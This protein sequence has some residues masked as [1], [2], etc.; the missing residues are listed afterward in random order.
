MVT[1]VFAGTMAIAGTAS[2]ANTSGISNVEVVE[3]GNKQAG[4]LTTL[5]VSFV[6]D[7]DGSS[8]TVIVNFPSAQFD[9]GFV[10][11]ITT[12]DVKFL[13]FTT[14]DFSSNSLAAG[15]NATIDSV[16]VSGDRKKL[17]VTL[18][19]TEKFLDTNAYQV[20]VLND[21]FENP[22]GT[23]NFGV[24]VGPEGELSSSGQTTA[25]AL[26]MVVHDEGGFDIEQAVSF[27]DGTPRVQAVLDRSVN[28]DNFEVAV[29]N[30]DGNNVTD[31]VAEST[32]DNTVHTINLQGS[33]DLTGEAKLNFTD[34]SGGETFEF[35]ITTGTTTLEDGTAPGNV[36]ALEG[37]SVAIFDGDFTSGNPTANAAFDITFEGE[38][39]ENKSLGKDADVG[40]FETEGRAAGQYNLSLDADGSPNSAAPDTITVRAF[41]FGVSADETDV[42]LLESSGTATINATIDS[43]VANRDAE[44]RLFDS[45]GDEIDNKTVTVDSDGVT[46]FDFV[47]TEEDDYDI[48]V[49]DLDTGVTDETATISVGEVTGEAS[50]SESVYNDQKGDVI[51]FTVNLA[52]SDT[53]DVGIGTEAGQSGIGYGA[54]FTVDDSDDGD[55]QVT[56]QF[57]TR[58]PSA[59]P[60][61][62]SDDD[63][64]TGFGSSGTPEALDVEAYDVNT[65]VGSGEDDVATLNLNDVS[66]DGFALYAA[67]ESSTIQDAENASEI[68]AFK[69]AGNFSEASSIAFGDYL[70]HELQVSGLEGMFANASS[71]SDAD[72][73]DDLLTT[74]S[75]TDGRLF[76]LNITIEESD[77]STAANSDKKIL[78][79]SR[80]KALDGEADTDLDALENDFGDFHVIADGDADT[81]YIGFPMTFGDNTEGNG[82]G[83]DDGDEFDVTVNITDTNSNLVDENVSVTQTFTVENRS[84][85]LDTERDESGDDL[86]SLEADS[87]QVVTGTT[88]LAPGSE[89]DIRLRATGENPFLLSQTVETDAQRNYEA[90]FDLSDRAVG[91]EFEVTATGPAQTAETVD[92]VVVESTATETPEPTATPTEEPTATPTEE[93]T[94]TPTEEPT[95]TETPG[96]PGFGVIVALLAFMAAALLAIRRD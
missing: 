52:N 59:A 9:N 64:I 65:S 1:S 87:G 78:L 95:A 62:A 20:R 90:S 46:T 69:Q 21:K 60:T 32:Q 37:E 94:A 11:D 27:D 67:P 4:N 10:N 26:D 89:I 54:T 91:L 92:A 83:L 38:F 58:D 55:G 50:F 77:D 28:L 23:T 79:D 24:E 66:A 84:V 34:G 57:N 61:A 14:S 22:S 5:N 15:E 93:P 76:E 25:N 17:T 40:V 2:A 35:N 43:S 18:T 31:T 51:D 48:E 70:Y 72:K 39:I 8:D 80:D 82:D 47:V 73:L 3:E 68:E 36:T 44:A 81:Y 19:D 41:T 7:N 75:V 53:A 16:A 96:Q 49:E 12:D 42:D 71:S 6:T 33:A 56:V 63:A 30:R 29:L 85:E 74:D 13:N 86:I 88:N 45:S